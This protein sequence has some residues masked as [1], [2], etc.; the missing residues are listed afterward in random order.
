MMTKIY[1]FDFTGLDTIDPFPE[2]TKRI[3]VSNL[4]ITRR[5]DNPSSC[6]V[7][8]PSPDEFTTFLTSNPTGTMT[9]SEILNGVE[10]VVGTYTLSQYLPTRSPSAFTVVLNGQVPEGT[11]QA[12][13]ISPVTISN[14]ITSAQNADGTIRFSAE[15]NALIVVDDIINVGTGT[16]DIG[17]GEQILTEITV[18]SISLFVNVSNSRM[19]VGAQ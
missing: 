10:S 3:P 11:D 9:I 1:V 2:V 6:S 16:F 17:T 7:T 13:T 19:D 5:K 15:E 12:S 4:S 14:P 8:I 18:R